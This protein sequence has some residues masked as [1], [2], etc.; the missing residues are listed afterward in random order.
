MVREG[1]PPGGFV[2][3]LGSDPVI[4]TAVPRPG[5][6][7]PTQKRAPATPDT[8][9]AHEKIAHAIGYCSGPPTPTTS[10]GPGSPLPGARISA[11]APQKGLRMAGTDPARQYFGSAGVPVTICFISPK[12]PAGIPTTVA[13]PA[14]TALLL[15]VLS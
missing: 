5:E 6:S 4:G 2:G 14:L 13:T 8:G 9:A 15:W 12:I 1:Q 11:S 10:E 7:I 3:G